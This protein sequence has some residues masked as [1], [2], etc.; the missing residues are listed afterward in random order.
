MVNTTLTY[1][2]VSAA[3]AAAVRIERRYVGGVDGSL[4]AITYVKRITL[5]RG[6]YNK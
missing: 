3:A 5:L 2:T 4:A 1:L 6:P